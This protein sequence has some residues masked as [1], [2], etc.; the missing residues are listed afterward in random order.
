MK[1]PIDAVDNVPIVREHMLLQSSKQV[2]TDIN[3]ELTFLLLKM[4]S[5][6]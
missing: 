6:C 5:F 3:M 4:I 1:K 2:N